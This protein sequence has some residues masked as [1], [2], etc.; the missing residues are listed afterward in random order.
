MCGESW[1]TVRLFNTLPQ[2]SRLGIRC[3]FFILCFLVRSGS[4]SFFLSLVYWLVCYTAIFIHINP[5]YH[6]AVPGL[7]LKIKV[8]IKLL[9][10][11]ACCAR[12]LP[13]LYSRRMQCIVCLLGGTWCTMQVLQMCSRRWASRFVGC[14][15]PSSVFQL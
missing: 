14:F 10:V 4:V 5:S 9:D 8:L 12:S 2:F 3:T 7:S 1:I 6:S 13:S 15:L 11:H